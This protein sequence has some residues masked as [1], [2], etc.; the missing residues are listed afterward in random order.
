LIEALEH[1][2][3]EDTVYVAVNA[4]PCLKQRPAFRRKA[5]GASEDRDE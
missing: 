4:S 2:M 3:G 5:A 1:L